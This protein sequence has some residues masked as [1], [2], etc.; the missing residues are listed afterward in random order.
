MTPYEAVREEFDFPFE[1]Y[2]FQIDAVNH[3]DLY[4]RLGLYH[5]AGSGKTATSTHLALHKS[6][7]AGVKHWLMPMPPILTLQW[8]RWLTLR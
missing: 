3:L 4:D 1:L 7:T 5:E 2:P 6:L 8:Q